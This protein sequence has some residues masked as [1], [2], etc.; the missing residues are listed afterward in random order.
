[1]DL[2][3]SVAPRALWQYDEPAPGPERFI[4][5]RFDGYRQ[6]ARLLLAHT[7]RSAPVFV[8]GGARSDFTRLNPLLYRLQQRGIG[9]L[10]GNLSGHSRASEPGAKDA[11]LASNLQEALRFHQHLDS[12]SD[13][14]IG[15][16][17][18]GALALKLAAQ[19]SQ[20]RKLVLICPAVY[21]DAAHAAPF[22]PAFSEAIRKPFAFLDCD[23]YAFLRQFQ[24]RV[25][26]VVGEYDGLNSKVHGQG[27]GTS[28]GTRN[29]AGVERYSPI[30][31]EVT[32]TLLRSVPARHVECLMLT[33][34]DHGIAAHL[35]DRPQVADQ[36]AE[37]VA[38][39]ILD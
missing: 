14:V 26:L 20:V 1:M 32:H 34:C 25:L 16:S 15:H 33:D 3:P 24:G 30:P 22:G 21:P 38:A 2:E 39:F 29:L 9:S 8:V 28:A 10:T 5:E 31:E 7:E 18:G 11:S 35:R 23:S 36:V 27:P 17:L 13:T 12:R 37:S 19:R 6:Q 4:E